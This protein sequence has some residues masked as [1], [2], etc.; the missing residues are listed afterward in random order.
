MANIA[1]L[2]VVLGLNSSEFNSEYSFKVMCSIIFAAWLAA[3]CLYDL[4]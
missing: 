2:G 3:C 1:R 4:Y